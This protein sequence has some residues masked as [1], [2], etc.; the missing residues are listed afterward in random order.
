V[1]TVKITLVVTAA[2]MV[3]WWLHL[4]AKIWPEHSVLA[5]FL[6][7]LTLCIVLQLVWSEPKRAMMPDVKKDS[8][9]NTAAR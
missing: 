3:A 6:M 4:P 8:A 5:G 7:A 9:E 2:L 1:K